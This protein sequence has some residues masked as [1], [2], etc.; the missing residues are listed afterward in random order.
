MSAE[1]YFYLLFDDRKS[2]PELMA[3]CSLCGAITTEPLELAW[4]EQS[5][6]CSNCEIVMP[7][8]AGVLGRLRKQAIEVQSTIDSLLLQHK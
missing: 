7:V 3:E 4:L 6:T 5:V 1:G 2:A 8:T